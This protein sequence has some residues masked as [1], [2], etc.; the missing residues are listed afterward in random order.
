MKPKLIKFNEEEEEAIQNYAN[1]NTKGN[2]TKAVS[3]L[4]KE[5]IEFNR[6]SKLDGLG[7]EQ[8]AKAEK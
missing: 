5:A 7:Y 2:Y 6:L 1:H 8:L 4:C 3:K